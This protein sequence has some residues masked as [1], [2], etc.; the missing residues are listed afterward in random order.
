MPPSSLP[1]PFPLPPVPLEVGPLNT[2]RGTGERAV[3]SP[4]GVWGGNRIWCIL[5]LNLTS[6]GT[7]FTNFPENQLT[8]V[9][10]FFKV[11]QENV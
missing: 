3:S 7:K 10:A 1:F 6:G 4:S 5:A 9:Y 11:A 8:T 2:A